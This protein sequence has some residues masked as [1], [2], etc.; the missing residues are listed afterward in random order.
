M[1][2]PCSSKVLTRRSR[3]NISVTRPDRLLS[4]PLLH[5]LCLPTSAGA[6][7][8]E[9]AMDAEGGDSAARMRSTASSRVWP[10]HNILLRVQQKE[11]CPRGST[12]SY[13]TLQF[14][15]PMG[16]V[17]GRC[18]N[19]LVCLKRWTNPR[20][21][22]NAVIIGRMGKYRDGGNGPMIRRRELLKS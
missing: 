14:R 4:V 22:V 7:W 9:W 20:P 13:V 15:G 6:V 17:W 5:F 19:Y 11:W 1:S 10:R 21:K 3:A 2:R 8:R 18:D 16:T 12:R